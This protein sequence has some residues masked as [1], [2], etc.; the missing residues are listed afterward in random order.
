MHKFWKIL[1]GIAAVLGI[2]YYALVKF[3]MPGYLEKMIPYAEEAAKD[4]IIGSVEIG[5]LGWNGGFEAEFTDVKIRDDVGDIVAEIPRSVV[6]VRPWL[7]LTDPARALSSVHFF[8][9]K[10][11]LTMDDDGHWNLQHFL[12]ETEAEE[13]PFYGL[14]TITEGELEVGMPC[15]TWDFGVEGTVDGGANPNFAVDTI[16]NGGPDIIIMKGIVTDKAT[17]TL[18][19]TAAKVNLGPYA[20]IVNFYAPLRNLEGIISGLHLVWENDGEKTQLSGEGRLRNVGGRLFI[21]EY[22]FKYEMDFYNDGFISA[23][24]GILSVKELNTIVNGQQFFL[25]GEADLRDIENVSANG[26]LTAPLLQWDDFVLKDVVFPFRFYENNVWLDDSEMTYQGGEIHAHGIYDSAEGVLTGFMDVENVTQ[27]VGE[28]NFFVNGTLGLLIRKGVNTA[29][30]HMAADTF[31][32]KWRDMTFKD[33]SMDGDFDGEKINIAHISAIAG[34]GNIA[35]TGAVG[36]DGGLDLKGR[37]A[38]FPI[39]PFLKEVDENGKGLCSVAFKV[40]GTVKAPEYA[41]I[42]Q[43]LN[44]DVMHQKIRE[45]HGVVILKDNLLT[46]RDYTARMDQGSHVIDGTIDLNNTDNPVFDLNIKSDNVRIEPLLKAAGQDMDIT[47][48]ITGS[49]HV[50][51][52][53]DSFSAQGDLCFSQGSIEGYLVDKVEG[54]YEFDPSHLEINNV[55]ITALATQAELNGT[56]SLVTNAIDF[57]L[58]AKDLDLDRL[59]IAEKDYDIDGLVNASGKLTGYL[60]RPVFTGDVSSDKITVNGESLTDISGH[61]EMDGGAT[62]RVVASFKQPYSERRG[63]GGSFDADVNYN[64]VDNYLQGQ[65]VLHGGDLHQIFN[66][67]KWD[68]DID[69]TLEGLVDINPKGPRSGWVLRLSANDVRIHRLHYND[70]LFDAHVINDVLYLDNFHLLEKTGVTDKGSIIIDGQVDFAGRTLNVGLNA[71]K[72]DPMLTMAFVKDPPEIKGE[73]NI[74]VKAEGS[75]DNPSGSADAEIVNGS[76]AGV[77]IDAL[78][79][80]FT[81]V[82][83]L[84]T[85]TEAYIARDIYNVKAR[86]F[87]PVDL[88]RAKEER[89]D[90]GA[91][92]KIDIDMSEAQLGILPALFKQIEWATGETAGNITLAGTLEE[93][94]TLGSVTIREGCVKIKDVETVVDKINTEINFTGDQV[95]LNDLSTQLGKGTLAFDGSYGLRNSEDQSY[96]L[97][98]VAKDAEIVSDILTCRMNSEL[99][100]TPEGYRQRA[101]A[102]TEAES[103]YRPKVSGNIRVD[104]VLFNMPSIPD[105]GDGGTNIGLDLNIELGPK[106]HLFNKLFYDLWVAGGLQ[107]EGSSLFPKIS[108]SLKVDHGSVTYLR[109]PFKLKEA[110]LAWPVQGTFFPTVNIEGEARFSRYDIYVT[111]KGPVEDMNMKLTSNPP[112]DQNTIMRMLTLQRM[113][114]G[115]SDEIT[116]EDVQNLMTAGLQMAF[117]GDVEMMLKQSLGIDQFRIYNGQIRSGVGF[118]SMKKQSSRELNTDDKNNYNMLLSKYFTPHLMIGYT[119]SFNGIDRSI[120]G[121]YDISRHMNFAYSRTYGLTDPDDWVGLEYRIRF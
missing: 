58:D 69:A 115:N 102:T 2:L 31:D 71:V 79:T 42:L 33:L 109:T 39:D 13:T 118:E 3:V 44:M 55:K 75:F 52:T 47:G 121:Q 87:F 14:V 36:L 21:T 18:N 94:L 61:A 50:W 104:D 10:V 46:L 45:A 8:S 68:Y 34:Q 77:P 99:E 54:S 11:Y 106:I 101:T 92:M 89:R 105:M 37:M 86:G 62:N 96:R 23:E 85:L 12:R 76:F 112:L 17:G 93:P 56:M 97:H 120:F 66:M 38:E 74:K 114:P 4:Y 59:P 103:G 78:K 22:G 30:V 5:G 48:D 107:I 72:A 116:S 113:D 49:T 83:D 6:T 57:S 15:G 26:R 91:Q 32:A 63:N 60:N 43:F 16:L 82:D 41:G 117:L 1:A 35:L 100:I 90:P 119:T 25:F 27:P 67:A 98:V 7:A 24:D 95:L 64:M 80:K 9:P 81:L 88:V 53:P 73:M 111:I 70:M 29:F 40:E 20:P 65:V 110:S 108:G 51:G 84:V 19:I 28:E